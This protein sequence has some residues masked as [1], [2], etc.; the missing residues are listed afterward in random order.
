MA[1]LSRKDLT[2][3]GAYARQGN[4]ELHWNYLAQ[5]D[6]ADGYGLLALGVVRNDNLP[7]QVA[8]AYA[9]SQARTQNERD[10][11]LDSRI[12]TEREW[13]E[14]GQTLL[15]RD[16]ELRANWLDRGNA[17]LALN[18]PG[19]D[20]QL[21]HDRAFKA[22][23]LDPNCWTPRILLEATRKKDGEDAAEIVWKDMLNN[24][25]LG[26]RRAMD[27]AGN[28]FSAMPW[29]EASMYVAKLGL[30]E[31]AM[32]NSILTTV[33]GRLSIPQR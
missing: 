19:R 16:L 18:L 11:V 5:K 13:D 10:T 6:G 31:A 8:N 7:G 27:T 33:T 1:G 4:R 21:A 12:L 14:F 32:A 2:V 20:V 30:Y 29:D 15:E 25:A 23:N 9:Q 17:E 24:D 28:A 26:T 3:L 22:H